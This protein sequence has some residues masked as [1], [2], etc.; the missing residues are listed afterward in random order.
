MALRQFLKCSSCHYQ[1]LSRKLYT[2]ECPVFLWKGSHQY[3]LVLVSELYL[4]VSSAV[5]DNARWELVVRGP[6]E[7]AELCL[8]IV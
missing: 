3:P 2:K 5:Q 6:P 4:T 8:S 7:G 1:E